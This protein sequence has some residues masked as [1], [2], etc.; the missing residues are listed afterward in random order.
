MSEEW[1]GALTGSGIARLAPFALHASMARS[2][3]AF[4]P[5]ITTWPGALKFNART[6]PAPAARAPRPVRGV[7]RGHH[8][9]LRVDRLV[10]FLRRPLVEELDEIGTQRLRG[11]APD[12]L[13][14]RQTLVPA[15]HSDCLR[16]LSRENHRELHS[17]TTEEP[18]VKP[19][20]TPWSRSR[21]PGRIFPC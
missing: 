19:P 14:F 3:A 1:N 15:Q 4:S 20:P 8:R 17:V 7:A 2:T 18:Q 6:S 9:R 13:H 11:F 5:A 10:Q 16:A 21:S 12:F